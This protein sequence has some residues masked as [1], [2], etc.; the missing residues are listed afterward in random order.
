MKFNLS[1]IFILECYR[2]FSIYFLIKFHAYIKLLFKSLNYL[3]MA[4][5]IL[6][7]KKEF[8]KNLLYLLKN[9]NLKVLIFS[10]KKLKML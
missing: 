4:V 5:T 6:L 1:N 10:M 2:K 9:L 8:L 3:S 7:K